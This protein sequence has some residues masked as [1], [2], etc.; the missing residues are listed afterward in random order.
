MKRNIKIDRTSVA[1]HGFESA[2]AG[3]LNLALWLKE[4]QHVQRVVLYMV[5][6]YMEVI[7]RRPFILILLVFLSFFG[8]PPHIKTNSLYI[9][10]A[11]DQQTMSCEQAT[12]TSADS[13]ANRMN[14]LGCT[15][16]HPVLSLSVVFGFSKF[17]SLLLVVS[18]ILHIVYTLFL[19]LFLLVCPFSWCEAVKFRVKV[20]KQLILMSGCLYL[21]FTGKYE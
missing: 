2:E 5:L 17:H 7:H 4:L 19:E 10:I 18:K 8:R 11:I 15:Y 16:P 3:K 9:L 13:E 20:D 14:Y 1:Y 21:L 6:F 12:K